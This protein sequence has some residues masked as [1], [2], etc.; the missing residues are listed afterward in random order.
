MNIIITGGGTGGH[1]YPALS[2]AQELIRLGHNVEFIG[3]ERGLEKELFNANC[4][5]HFI[6]IMGFSRS[7]NYESIKR[8]LKLISVI[9]KAKKMSTKIISDAQAHVVVAFGGYVTYPVAQ[10]AE[11]LN[12]PIILHEQ[13]SVMGLANK[14]ASKY[15]KQIISCFPKI[16]NYSKK[17]NFLG[18]PRESDMNFDATEN[19]KLFDNDNPIVLISGGSQG[20]MYFNQKI[21]QLY[22]KINDENMNIVHVTG[23]N[24][25]DEYKKYESS[26]IKI[27][28]YVE[29]F[30]VMYKNTDYF[31]LRAG[32]TT[33]AEI[34][35]ISKPVIL[36]PSPYVT[37]DHQSKNAQQ[38]KGTVFSFSEANINKS[39]VP[40]L[41]KIQNEPL[42]VKEM[43]RK[44]KKFAKPNAL[45]DIVNEI[46]KME[47]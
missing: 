33:I 41:E 7:M 10:A 31:V 21:A 25:Y 23:K 29:D 37:N 42:F 28:D 30:K 15:A 9:R 4:P 13:N 36:V 44:R 26:K 47:G 2:V 24:Y 3:S 1:I 35:N 12:V 22:S 40:T 19:I 6:S 17:V 34:R 11:K 14:Q 43:I 46:L 27:I 20:A 38:L 8:N 16:E 45:N 39:L 18:N 5:K 32:A